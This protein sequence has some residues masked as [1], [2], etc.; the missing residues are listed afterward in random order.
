LA[1]A[2][3]SEKSIGK[4]PC[5]VA[6]KGCEGQAALEVQHDGFGDSTVMKYGEHVRIPH[7]PADGR[8]VTRQIDLIRIFDSCC[9]LANML[10][11]DEAVDRWALIDFGLRESLTSRQ[12]ND[13]ERT[14]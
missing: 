5:V 1:V 7:Q 3:N 11:Q 9:T 14:R 10:E 8:K 13:F 6:I 12:P 2:N 4:A